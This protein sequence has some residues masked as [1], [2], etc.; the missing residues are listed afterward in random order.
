MRKPTN[1]AV[2]RGVSTSVP[3]AASWIAFDALPH[4]VREVIWSAPVSVNPLTIEPLLAHGLGEAIAALRGAIDREVQMF[5]EQHRQ[6]H[7]CVLPH[8]A[9]GVT[10]QGYRR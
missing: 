2:A 6:A 3:R 8:V 1:S 5:A 9:A 10:L 7:G 4:S